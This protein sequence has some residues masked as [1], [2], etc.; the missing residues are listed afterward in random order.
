MLNASG[1][2]HIHIGPL[3]GSGLEAI[4][5]MLDASGIDRSRFINVPVA[6]TLVTRFAMNV[7]I[8]S[9]RRDGGARTAVEAMA[10]G[11]PMVCIRLIQVRIAFACRWPGPARPSGVVSPT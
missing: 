10:A 6:R 2:T 4:A 3:S 5:A 1:G 9:S 8:C 7:S 11:V